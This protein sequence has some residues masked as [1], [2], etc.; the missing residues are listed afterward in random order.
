MVAGLEGNDAV[1]VHVKR[2]RAEI[3]PVKASLGREFEQ[4]VLESAVWGKRVHYVGGFCAN[5]GRRAHAEPA[6]HPTSKL[7]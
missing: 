4:V 5:R 1:T 2:L 6:S 3:L 7:G